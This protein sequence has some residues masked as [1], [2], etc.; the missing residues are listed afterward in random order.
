MSAP[1]KP[2]TTRGKTAR[3]S[4][5]PAFP[6][7]SAPPAYNRPSR[8]AL[9]PAMYESIHNA[10]HYPKMKGAEISNLV[11]NSMHPDAVGFRTAQLQDPLLWS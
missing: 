1:S 8:F 5:T 11:V 3:M 7:S 6:E 2:K 9:K 4:M 10:P